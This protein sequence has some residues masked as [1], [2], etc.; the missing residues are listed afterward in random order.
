MGIFMYMNAKFVYVERYI[1]SQIQSLYLDVIK[2]KCKIEKEILKNTL[3]IALTQPDEFAYRYMEGPGYMAA[4]AGEVIHIVQCVPVDIKIQ[5][6]EKCYNRMP[7]KRGNHSLFLTPRTHIITNYTT[8]LPCNSPLLQ[9]YK[10]GAQWYKFTPKPVETLP[11]KR[12]KPSTQ[13]T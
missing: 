11:P 2:N 5:Q 7:I 9:H 4:A 3:S 13:M 10:L 1:R 8:E 12:L 6:S